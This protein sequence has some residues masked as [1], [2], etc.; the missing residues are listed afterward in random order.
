MLEDKDHPGDLID[1]GQVGQITSIDPSLI[2]HLDKGA[3]IPVIAPI[4]VGK[5]ARPTTSMLTSSP[6]KLLKSSRPKNWCC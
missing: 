2:D 1:V 3:F 6:A 5:M 4:G